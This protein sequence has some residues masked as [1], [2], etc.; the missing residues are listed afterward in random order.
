MRNVTL[1]L[2][3]IGIGREWGNIPSKMLNETEAVGFLRNSFDLG[4][5]FFDTAPSYGLSE[6]KLGLF[7]ET[8]RFEDRKNICV[9]TK[10]GEH[11]NADT[12]QPYV[13]HTYKALCNSVDA[14]LTRLGRIDLFQLHKSNSAVLQSNDFINSLEYARDK[15]ISNFGV[16]VGDVET[17]EIA[18]RMNSISTIQM[19]FNRLN[20]SLEK[21]FKMSVDNNKTL[22]INRPFNTGKNVSSDAFGFILSRNF[23]GVILSGTTSIDHLRENIKTFNVAVNNN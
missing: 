7:L 17:G 1:G 5:R 6:S 9:T 4:I 22:I 13:D 3:L 23:N 21:L 2:G 16:S 20:Q 14:S 18:M 10:F 11:W 12:N 8:L 15:G 19:P